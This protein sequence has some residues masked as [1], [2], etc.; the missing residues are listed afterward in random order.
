MMFIICPNLLQRQQ[1]F[2]FGQDCPFGSRI[3]PLTGRDT[4]MKVHR[5]ALFR[6]AH[7][8][9]LT[10]RKRRTISNDGLIPVAYQGLESELAPMLE[11]L[12]W[13][14]QASIVPEELVQKDVMNY[15][16]AWTEEDDERYLVVDVFDPV[17]DGSEYYLL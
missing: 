11:P 2:S 4:D 7:D 1:H 3:T 9:F 14:V 12:R 8:M 17:D 16:Q 5:D 13:K 10:A 6:V 15:L